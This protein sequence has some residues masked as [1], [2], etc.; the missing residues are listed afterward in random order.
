MGRESEFDLEKNSH[1]VSGG[2]GGGG[3]GEPGN[4]Q[5][6]GSARRVGGAKRATRLKVGAVAAR[7]GAL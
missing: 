7:R 6:A 4:W 2:G 3:D 5:L 1:N